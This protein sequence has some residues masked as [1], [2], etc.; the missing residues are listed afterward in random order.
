MFDY[1]KI[2]ND[3]D[4]DVETS[5]TVLDAVQKWADIFNGKE[6][7]VN[8]QVMSI[9]VAKSICETVAKAVTIEYKSKCSDEN[10]DKIYQK[11]LK[12]IRTNTEYG[13]AKSYIFFKPYYSNGTIKIS[14][15]QAD[16]CIPFKFSNDGDLLGMITVDQIQDGNKVY[17]RLE[18]N[19]LIDNT[20]QIKNIAYEGEV[21]GSILNKRI[22]LKKV[23]KWKD[24]DEVA[25]IGG[26][27][28]LIGGFFTMPNANTLDNS[29]P[30]GQSIFHDAI[31]TLE[32]IDKQ[33]SRAIWEFEGSEL[34]I[35]VDE[36]MLEHDKTGK[37][38]YPT[39]K[40][41]LFR[42]LSFDEMKDKNYNVFSPQIRDTSLF[43]GL[44]ELLRQAET[45]CQI[46]FGT[47]SKNTN[48]AKTATEIKNSKQDYYVTV[49]DIQTAMEYALNDLVYGIYVLCRLY[50]IPVDTNYS[51]SHDWDD[52]ILVDKET[53]R[54]QALIERNNKLT[55]D[56][57]Y[58]METMDMNEEDAIEYVRNIRERRKLFEDPVESEEDEE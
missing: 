47:I 38:K 24:I 21:N 41:R 33:I 13:I 29:S 53:K 39:G 10:I 19:E 12:R 23:D 42:G 6:P 54:N 14:V 15:V 7:W 44:N 57:Q 27:D 9:H 3:F 56:V 46:A 30:L 18:Y 50:G 4:I 28:R 1:N 5:K 49:S 11:F 32:Q 37:V 22:D 55:D 45:E 17:T 35:D 40:K 34:A 8:D 58:F 20:M 26:I 36:S 48:I 16:K 2:A 51:M 31:G 25:S 43:N 52:S